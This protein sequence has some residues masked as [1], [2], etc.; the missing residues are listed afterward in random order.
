MLAT[1]TRARNMLRRYRQIKIE[2]I[3]QLNDLSCIILYFS[4]SLHELRSST[5]FL[6]NVKAWYCNL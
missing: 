2:Q 6:L 1:H 5:A 4:L 3:Y